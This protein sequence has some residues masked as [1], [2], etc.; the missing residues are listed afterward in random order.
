M[1]SDQS[2]EQNQPEQP[3][4]PVAPHH[5]ELKAATH[6]LPRYLSDDIAP[7]TAA[8]FFE[9]LLP[10]SPEIAARV[11][12]DWVSGQLSRPGAHVLASDLVYHSLRKLYLLAEFELLPREQML[13]Y[14]QGASRFLVQACPVA[15]RDDLKLR[16][17]R[18]GEGESAATGSRAKFLHGGSGGGGKEG[19]AASASAAGVLAAAAS[20]LGPVASSKLGAMPSSHLGPVGS[21]APPGPPP[22]AQ[23][24]ERGTRALSLLL[25][26]LSQVRIPEN[27]KLGDTPE[28]G[29]FAQLLTTAALDSKSETELGKNMEKIRGTGN[30]APMGQVFRALGW[31]LPGWT[32]VGPQG[33]TL[34]APAGRSLE[35]MNRIVA[36]APDS[37]ERAKRWGEMI[38]AAIEQLNEGRLAQTV[39]ILEAAKALIAEKHP[40]PT[41]VGQVLSQAEGAIAEP[42][43]RKLVDIPGKHALLRLVL[44]FFPGMRAGAL[45]DELDGEP[46]R[47]RRKLILALLECHGE[48]CRD[49]ILDRIRAITAGEKPDPQGH[50]S[51]NLAFLLRRI[52]R[53]GHNR[54]EEEMALLEKMIGKGQPGMS[55]KEAIGALG[56][57]RERTAEC[58][59]LDRLH[60]M[61][62]ELA[63]GGGDSDSWELLDRICAGLARH[64]SRQSI[65]A[66]AAHAFKR[67]NAFGDTMARLEHLGWVDL[68]VD[69]EQLSILLS[70]IR[71]LMPKKLLGFSMKRPPADLAPLVHAVSGTP[72]MEVRSALE[73]I[74]AALKNHPLGEQA[75]KA[76]AKLAPKA[77]ATTAAAETLNG[78]L[79]LFGLAGLLQ[80]LQ[81]SESTGELTIVDRQ[82]AA[83]GTIGLSKGRIT[84][85]EAGKLTGVEAAYLLF[86]KPV[87]GTFSFRST[88]AAQAPRDAKNLAVDPMEVIL[89]G[90]RRHDEYQRARAIAPDGL[91]LEP[92]GIAAVRPEDENSPDLASDVWDRAAK[93]LPPEA[94][95]HEIA[96]DPFR[97]RRLYAWWIEQG[98]LRARTV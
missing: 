88:S 62:S 65:R 54:L 69:P 70:T 8:E 16:L 14:I 91:R 38:Y 63:R 46:R 9:E 66:V 20:K 11:I 23:Q 51:R 13:T 96:I 3:P 47:D 42:V 83:L 26:R 31:N 60:E 78:D 50:Y 34:A 56:Q 57:M 52:P 74:A 29:S 64:G 1:S 24:I 80:S 36:L 58:A 87:P 19:D 37:Q 61:E 90:A 6:E 15:E 43:L 44:D 41:I 48:K 45:L 35:A 7:L 97:V 89:E 75:T 10:G 84:K 28:V 22:S 73:A 94:C 95:E 67:H 25:D 27:A 92:A 77:T 17:S 18:L 55:A 76:L 12:A 39:S 86:E 32:A 68:S 21:G 33:D 71:E 72:T 53:K 5:A 93:G 2:P 4:E 85:C 49:A 81:G 40:D 30:A 79:E 82:Q 59:L 98:A